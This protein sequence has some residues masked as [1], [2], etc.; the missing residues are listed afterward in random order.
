MVTGVAGTQAHPANMSSNSDQKK[1][2]NR[3]ITFSTDNQKVIISRA[4]EIVG[5][6]SPEAPDN[7][8]SRR[9]G[10]RSGHPVPVG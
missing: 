10:G 6:A 9:V 2:D 7:H 4:H 5:L 1:G 8:D 3:R